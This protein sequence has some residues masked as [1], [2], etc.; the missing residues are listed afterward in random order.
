MSKPRDYFAV[1]VSQLRWL[2]IELRV[3]VARMGLWEDVEQT[4]ALAAW[5]SRLLGED[6]KSS[7][8][9]A[10][11]HLYRLLRAHGFR[12]PRGSGRFVR[13]EVV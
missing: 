13:V 7:S 3:L 10:Q 8:N 1:A 4:L 12:R 6:L 11:R 2:P 5:E 9:R